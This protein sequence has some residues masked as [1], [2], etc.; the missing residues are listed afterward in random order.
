MKDLSAK[1]LQAIP[2]M[3][4]GKTGK[5]VAAEVSVT[6]QTLCEWKKSALFMAELN[7]FRME[8]LETAR[9]ALQHA[10]NLAVAALV[11]L[12]ESSDNPETRRKAAL[13]ILRLTGFEPGH[14]EAYA[15][16]IGQ[17]TVEAAEHEINGTLNLYKLTKKYAV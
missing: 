4:Q 17:R 6:P 16:G 1:Q 13:D 8:A 14:Y 5:E 2:L 3:A 11:E 12:A 15:W 7:N 9:S 10:P